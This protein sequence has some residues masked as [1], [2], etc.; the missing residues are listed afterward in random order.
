M[1]LNKKARDGL[2]ME[3][4][5]KRPRWRETG[6][7]PRQSFLDKITKDMAYGFPRT[8]FADKDDV[9]FYKPVMFLT[10]VWCGAPK[11]SALFTGCLLLFSH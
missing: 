6:F 7:C 8:K 2:L 3:R 9:S 5:T 1:V 11:K 10:L 4:G